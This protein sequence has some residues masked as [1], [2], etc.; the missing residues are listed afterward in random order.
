MK[1]EK[2]YQECLNKLIWATEQL[3]GEVK[4]APLQSIAELIVDSMTGKWRYFHTPQH[5]FDVGGSDDAIEV[6]AALFH[7]I[8]YVQV[9]NSVN[10]NLSYYLAPFSKQVKGKIQI[11]P[12]TEIFA[13][14]IFEMVLSVFGFV[15]GQALS[16]FEGQNEFLSALVAAKIFEPILTAEQLF[17]LVACIEATIPFQKVK[18][19]L[20]PTERLYQ[21]LEKTA[22][23]FEFNFTETEL[24]EVV[25]KAVRVANRDVIGFADS[26]SA[27]FLDNTWNLLPETN[28]NMINATTYTVKDYRVS[29]QK[30]ESFMNHVLQPELVF[31][32]FHGEPDDATYERLTEA[33]RKNIKIG[34]LYLGS[35][36]FA[37]AF[38]EALSLR[39]GLNIPLSTMMGELPSQAPEGAHLE[40]YIPEITDAYKPQNDLEKEVVTLLE[41]GRTQDTDYDIKHSPTATFIVKSV[42]FAEIE[43]QLQRAQ[44]FFQESLSP[45]DFIAGCNPKVTEAVTNAVLKLF[46]RRKAALKHYSLV[47]SGH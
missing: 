26:S 34:R 4:L 16:P 36:L 24:I 42:G 31:R 7:D 9:D 20:S 15:P 28:H 14:P 41:R 30:M 38:I 11:R 47:S 39:V 29:L 1:D 19:G 18:E 32:Q 46:D 8:V 2:T 12:Q 5:I 23:T 17:Q 35:K 13:D 10:F 3:T 6:L 44:A 43:K 21:R 37:T 25:K 27:K 40:D 22:A 33:A 45:E